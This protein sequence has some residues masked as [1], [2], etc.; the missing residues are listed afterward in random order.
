MPR[1]QDKERAVSQYLMSVYYVEGEETPS[2]E[3][4]QQMYQDVEALNQ[5]M[6]DQKVW[7]F[8]GGL[9]TPDTATVVRSED[10]EILTTDGPFPEAKEQIGGFWII[11]TENLDAALDWASQATVA[12]RGP[13]EI[14]PFQDEPEG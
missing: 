7:V 5:K 11:E 1:C 13:V 14:R 10:N 8:G 3:V 2:D 6:Q 4:I 12:C 9:H